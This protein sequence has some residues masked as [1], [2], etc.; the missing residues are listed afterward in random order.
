MMK[1]AAM[2]LLRAA[3]LYHSSLETPLYRVTVRSGLLNRLN[4]TTTTATI[5]SKTVVPK[6]EMMTTKMNETSRRDQANIVPQNSQPL[7]ELLD[8]TQLELLQQQLVPP[9]VTYLTRLFRQRGF[10]L[11]ICGG[12]VRDLLLGGGTTRINDIDLASDATPSQM[13]QLFEAHAIRMINNNGVA[14]GTVTC[15]LG[16][17]VAE[18]DYANAESGSKKPASIPDGCGQNF[19]ITTLR[20]DKNHDG[21][22][23][24][25]EFCKDWRLDASR[26]D[27]TINSMF[28][29]IETLC[30]IDYFDGLSD[31]RARKIRFVGD[32]ELRIQED[33]LRILRFFRYMLRIGQSFDNIEE[34]YAKE[35][36]IIKKNVKGIKRISTERIWSEMKQIIMLKNSPAI[37][38]CMD[39]CEI[40]ENIDYPLPIDFDCF[41]KLHS[42][43]FDLQPEVAT[44]LFALLPKNLRS[45]QDL[46]LLKLSNNNQTTI[47]FLNDNYEKF[48][49]LPSDGD[50]RLVFMEMMVALSQ[51]SLRSATVNNLIELCKFSCDIRCLE[52]I[53]QFSLPDMPINGHDV[54][55]FLESK[56]EQSLTVAKSGDK[57]QVTNYMS[58]LYKM[59]VNS[60]YK[61]SHKDM[62]KVLEEL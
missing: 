34:E 40:F 10:T 50:D 52:H 57:R 32:P 46:S 58:E 54:L 2:H 31:L 53:K 33:Y 14:H 42:E 43:C 9:N 47:L 39:N 16:L 36:G 15:R 59:W 37:I 55:K 21:R 25:V 13:Q 26:R 27:L 6:I 8:E 5:S 4:L 20:L 35:I 7:A 17:G 51:R 48:N 1:C 44:F 38:K 19:E 23:C 41:T 45:K 28:I 22:H 18:P 30:L 49:S 62:L 11:R 56:M 12:A 3:S 29:D 60:R 61:M 24:S